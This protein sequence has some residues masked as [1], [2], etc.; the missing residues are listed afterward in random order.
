M[1]DIS[2]TC[3]VRFVSNFMKKSLMPLQIFVLK[4]FCEQ[5]EACG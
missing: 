3:N 5:E 1:V 2:A 4:F